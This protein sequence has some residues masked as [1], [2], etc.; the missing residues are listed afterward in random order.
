MKDRMRTLFLVDGEHYPATILDALHELEIAE[1]LEPLALYFLGGTEKIRDISELAPSGA[2]II[3]P[4]EPLEAL[5]GVL[6]RLK[7]QLVADLSD[8]PVV[9]PALRMNLAAVSLAFGAVYRGGDFEF[10]PP[11]RERVLSKPSCAVIGSGKRCGKTAVSAE[12]ARFLDRSGRNPAECRRMGRLRIQDRER[13]R[14]RLLLL[15]PHSCHR[16]RSY[17]YPYRNRTHHLANGPPSVH[18]DP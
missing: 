4:E 17:P 3:V 5:A 1:G 16:Y 11:R 18:T 10:R 8:L 12:F 2:E 15:V 14:T 13:R 6:R 7:P 9:G